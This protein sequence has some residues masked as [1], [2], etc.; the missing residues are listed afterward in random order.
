MS[1][2]IRYLPELTDD[3]QLFVATLFRDMTEDQAEQYARV[4]RQRRKDANITLMTTLIGFM[5]LAG[6][7]RF[8][9]GQT[10]MGLLY[11]LT[12]GLC[13]VGTI[14]DAFKAKD[15]TWRFNEKQALDVAVMIRG[16]FPDTPLL[17][18]PDDAQ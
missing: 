18:K 2:I 12:G 1:K 14:V 7:Q 8:Y 15:L 10:G 3:E 17:P 5:G 6:V 13:L 4:Y 16:A 11:L 9:L